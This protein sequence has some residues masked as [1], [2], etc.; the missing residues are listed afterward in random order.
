MALLRES[1]ELKLMTFI[2]GRTLVD[3]LDENAQCYCYLKTH[4]HTRALRN[5]RLNLTTHFV[6]YF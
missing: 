1:C 5:K 2:K 6:S 4:I 3:Y